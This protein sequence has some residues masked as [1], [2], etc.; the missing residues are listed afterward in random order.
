MPKNDRTGLKTPTTGPEATNNY[1]CLFTRP[2][3]EL[4]LGQPTE[5]SS[6]WLEQ[7][8]LVLTF[9]PYCIFENKQNQII[10]IIQCTYKGVIIV[11]TSSPSADF[12]PELTLIPAVTWNS[13]P[14]SE[15][16]KL[17]QAKFIFVLEYNIKVPYPARSILQR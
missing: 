7:D 16:S 17:N 2:V 4:N 6:H 15:V 1:Y 13:L 3:K 14:S 12:L 9:W 10:V 5:K 11:S 8:N